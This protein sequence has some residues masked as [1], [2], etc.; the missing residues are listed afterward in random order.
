MAAVDRQSRGPNARPSTQPCSALSAKRGG[1]S[2]SRL[3]RTVRPAATL[4]THFRVRTNTFQHSAVRRGLAIRCTER[5]EP[6]TGAIP[7]E[8]SEYVSGPGQRWI[9]SIA[10]PRPNDTDGALNGD[11]KRQ[12]GVGSAKACLASWSS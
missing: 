9:R 2:P 5:R 10:T 4:A 6:T 11:A 8:V 3:L 12:A 7:A 1:L